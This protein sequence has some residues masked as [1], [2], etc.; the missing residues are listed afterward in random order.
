MMVMMPILGQGLFFDSPPKAMVAL[1]GHLVGSLC[2]PNGHT[3]F[4]C[5]TFRMKNNDAKT[6]MTTKVVTKARTPTCT[7]VRDRCTKQT[8]R[9]V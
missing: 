5:L 3:A 7:V 4:G 1:M 6:A 8:L 2:L 9:P